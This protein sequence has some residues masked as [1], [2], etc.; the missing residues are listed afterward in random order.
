MLWGNP[1]EER[2]ATLTW[3]NN[4]SNKSGF[5]LQR[6]TDAASTFN[7]IVGRVG[8]YITTFNAGSV[9]RGTDFYSRV[10]V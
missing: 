8:T 3:T 7:V 2:K 9:A 10:L 5:R 6:G 4:S 1:E